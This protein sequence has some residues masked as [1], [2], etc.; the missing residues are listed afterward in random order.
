MV[1]RKKQGKEHYK[2]ASRP[3]RNIC[4]RQMSLET[5]NPSEKK[6]WVRPSPR[7][8]VVMV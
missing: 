7:N 6:Y 1:K 2:T 8:T 5:K 4:R 3:R